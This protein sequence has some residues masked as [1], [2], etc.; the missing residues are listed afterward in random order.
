MA[1]GTAKPDTARSH[2]QDPGK[3]RIHNN[4]PRPPDLV[5]NNVM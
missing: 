4:Q 3:R 1:Q 5:I 2:I